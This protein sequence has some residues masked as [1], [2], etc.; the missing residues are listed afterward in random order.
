MKIVKWINQ[1]YD[2]L[3]DAPPSGS[4]RIDYAEGGYRVM[5][6]LIVIVIFSVGLLFFLEWL[7]K[8]INGGRLIH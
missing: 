1:Y 4:D 2:Y 3:F 8:M 7:F 6:L 5:P